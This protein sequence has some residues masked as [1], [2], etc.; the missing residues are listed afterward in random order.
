MGY[1]TSASGQLLHYVSYG[2]GKPV[3]LLHGFGATNYS[4]RH[5]VSQMPSGYQALSFDLKGFGDSP[6]PDDKQY[7]LYDQADLIYTFIIDNALN[8]VTLIGHSMGGGISLLVALK[9]IQQKE[10]RLSSLVLIDSIAYRQSIPF[11]LSFLQ[12]PILGPLGSALLPTGLQV[13][14][15]LKLAYYNDSKIANADVYAYAS[16]L[17]K[18]GSASAL[19]ESARQFI[20]RNIDQLANEYTTIDVPTLILWGREDAIVPLCVGQ[21]LH[22]AISGSCIAII[23]NC[24]HIP[25]EEC[26][27]EAIPLIVS[28]LSAQCT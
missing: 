1:P 14:A 25:H 13:R 19:V 15:V 12:M 7:S 23:D 20:P 6:K 18:P 10:K 28:F 11:F 8:G 5:L 4:W 3:I 26:A 24:G 22:A 2:T 17:Q 9:L 16:A 27:P 21:R